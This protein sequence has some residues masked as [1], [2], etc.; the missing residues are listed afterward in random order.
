MRIEGNALLAF[1]IGDQ[2]ADRVVP[3]IGLTAWLTVFVSAAMGFLTVFA[4]ALAL[5]TGRVAESWSAELERSATVRITAPNGQLETRTSQALD[6]LRTTPGI[7]TTRVIPSDEQRKLLEPWLGTDLP[8][9]RIP[10]PQLIEITT[11]EA[12]FHA[13]GLALR[14]AGEAPGAVLDDH[15]RWRAPMIVAASRVRALGIGA[16]VLIV[17]VMAAL[18]TLAARAS[19]SANRQ[20][21]TV[22]RLIG[23][24]DV[25]VARAFVRRLTIRTLL[26]TLIGTT[27]GIICIVLIPPSSEAPGLFS[28]FGFRGFEWLWPLTIPPVAAAIAFATTRI[29]AMTS[30]KSTR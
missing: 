10:L 22:L 15:E 4:I 8:F 28:A 2:K 27:L 16:V 5:T 14:L 9:E 11:D 29:T 1:L 7:V 30:L 24:R 17:G 12:E 6:V 26:G 25:Y 18:V 19:L 3:R 21:I 20:V 23:A 13:E